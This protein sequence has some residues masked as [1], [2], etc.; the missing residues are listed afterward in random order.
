M[1]LVAASGESRTSAPICFAAALLALVVGATLLSFWVATKNFE[2]A[3]P[4]KTP[5]TADV[6]N[7][8]RVEGDESRRMFARYFA[9]ES[10]R[11]MFTLL[12]PAQFVGCAGAFLLA[13]WK[14]RDFRRARLVR[15]LLATSAILSL[16]LALIVPAMIK[17]GRA[18]DFVSRAGGNPPEV[19]SFLLWH[20][21]YTA[22]DLV[23][24]LSAIALVPLLA[25]NST[26]EKS[27]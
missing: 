22:G 2:N 14:A 21:V 13:F 23:M 7:M 6:L 24:L 8:A 9:S 26:S 3:D 16:A 1:S 5:R 17:R 19:Q 20:H 25:L 10:N 15:T 12:G 18:I 27:S 4:A 11:A